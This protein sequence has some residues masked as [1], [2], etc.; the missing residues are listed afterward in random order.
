MEKLYGESIMCI[1]LAF[2]IILTQYQLSSIEQAVH[3]QRTVQVM[4]SFCF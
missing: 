2:H 4:I 3:H 1:I